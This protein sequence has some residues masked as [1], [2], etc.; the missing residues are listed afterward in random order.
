MEG[1][2]PSHTSPRTPPRVRYLCLFLHCTLPAFLSVGTDH[3][4]SL[5][6]AGL[7]KMCRDLVA[8]HEAF[9]LKPSDILEIETEQR[10]KLKYRKQ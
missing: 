3:A 10:N 7:G 5:E 4:A 9:T 1:C 6:P 8:T 2:A